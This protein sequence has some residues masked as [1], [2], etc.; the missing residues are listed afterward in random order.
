HEQLG[1][2]DQRHRAADEEHQQREQQVQGADV[3]VVGSEEPA[4]D[5][6]RLVVVVVV[7]GGGVRGHGGLPSI[8]MGYCTTATESPVVAAVAA[9]ALASASFCASQLSNCARG[10]ASITIGMKPWSLPHNS[11]HWPR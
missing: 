8:R 6:A 3:L 7:M 9:V 11:A 4:I 2:D 1:A 10:T 5:K